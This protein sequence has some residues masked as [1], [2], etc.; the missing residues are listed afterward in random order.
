MFSHSQPGYFEA[1]KVWVS[2]FKIAKQPSS[3]VQ[4]ES[5]GAILE[6]PCLEIPAWCKLGTFANISWSSL[7]TQETSNMPALPEIQTRE[8]TISSNSCSG[9]PALNPFL[10]KCT[11]LVQAQAGFHQGNPCNLSCGHCVVNHLTAV[12]SFFWFVCVACCS[13]FSLSWRAAHIH[14]WCQ[15]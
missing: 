10:C 6:A 8:L 4:A 5:S 1:T 12:Y 7:W 13:G 14:K 11:L 2:F 15:P 3:K 9:V